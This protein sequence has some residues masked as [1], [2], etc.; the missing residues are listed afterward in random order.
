MNALV[1]TGCSV[2][3]LM[4]II[5]F[6][7]LF[8]VF[9]VSVVINNK[10]VRVYVGGI[11]V[12]DSTKNIECKQKN[13]E[14]FEVNYKKYK[15]IINFVRKILDDKNDDLLYILKYINKTVNIKRIDVSLD[16]GF[17]DAALTG[18]TGGIIWG[19]I[20]NICAF[21]G[22]YIDINNNTNVAVKP[23]Y[24]DKIFDFKSEV[25]ISVRIRHLIKLIKHVKRFINTL[26]GGN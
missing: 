15:L 3:A 4:L 14:S 23:H 17:G 16:Y 5:L 11:K 8:A 10:I 2:A 24:T 13:E 18:I 6:I 9:K 21:V 1:I 7:A 22:N 19:V 26:K 20:S 12:Y 25:V